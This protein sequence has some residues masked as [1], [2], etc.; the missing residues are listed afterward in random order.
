MA[1][2]VKKTIY[3]AIKS[4][5]MK[6]RGLKNCYVEAGP[7]IYDEEAGRI[8]GY[9]EY[10]WVQYVTEKQSWWILYNSGVFMPVG[11]K[12][13]LTGRHYVQKSAA[14]Y[15]AKWTKF[16]ET[17]LASGNFDTLTSLNRLGLMM[18]DDIKKTYDAVVRSQPRRPLT[19]KIMAYA[20][21]ETGGGS[22]SDGTGFRVPKTGFGGGETYTAGSVYGSITYRV[23]NGT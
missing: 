20:N 9:L 11:S 2:D 21:A 15:R 14:Q 23:V 17:D 22:K 4:A 7:G 1:D 6:M 18:S 3:D 8:A 13:Q 19:Q 16:I 5:A 10:G 12:L